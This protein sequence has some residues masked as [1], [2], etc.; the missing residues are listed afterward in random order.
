MFL[1]LRPVVYVSALSLAALACKSSDTV[2]SSSPNAHRAATSESADESGVNSETSAPLPQASVTPPPAPSSVK[3]DGK[4][5]GK[6]DGKA[7]EPSERSAK[8]D[9][10]E[11]AAITAAANGAEVDQGRLARQKAKD[12]RVRDFGSMMVDHHGQAIQEQE[13]LSLQ[14]TQ[15]EESKRL[16]DDARDA[17]ESLKGKRGKEFDRAYLQLQIDEHRKVLRTLKEQL[18]PAAKDSQLK[19]YLENLEP[20]VE[21]H[22][23]QAERLQEELNGT[24]SLDDSS[25]PSISNRNGS[26]AR[27]S[28][29]HPDR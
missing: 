15:S 19:A 25:R 26:S 28:E 6:T 29:R 7:D 18:L 17:L 14:A 10:A 22:L 4:T 23:A 3:A 8:L 21:S 27:L 2:P 1:R 12:P 16:Q 9:D 11:I 24:S 13:K 20:K 5:D